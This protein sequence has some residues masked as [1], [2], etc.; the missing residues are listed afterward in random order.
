MAS[1]PRQ[2]LRILLLVALPWL[3]GN[4]APL[5]AEE[6]HTFFETKIRPI[7]VDHCST[8]H[9]EKLQ[10]ASLN[11]TTV[12]G[13]FKG[14]V[15]GPVVVK[16]DP[17]NSRIIQVV[18]YLDKI[19]MPPTGKLKEEEI[20]ALKAWV[21]MGTPWPDAKA[22]ATASPTSNEKY[23]RQP[24]R[25]WA[26][27]P[28]Q[29]Y[30]V[31]KVKDQSWIR[32]PIDSFILAKLEEQGLQPPLPADKLTL[33][34]RA[35]WDLH[36]LPPTRNEIEEFLS[37]D[38]PAAFS[39]LLDRLLASPR[40]GERWGRHWLDVARY[41]DSTGLDEDDPYY[42]GWR[43]RD[44]VID[45]FNKD[46]PFDQFIKEQ[47]AGDILAAEKGGVHESQ[48]VAT[49]FLA[50]GPKPIA[51]QDKVK[52]VY[53]VV[54]EQIDTTSKAFLGLTISCARCHDHKFDPI[55][56][57]DYYSLAA[58]FA[59]IRN[60]EDLKPVSA[61]T[62]VVPLVSK[63]VY[64]RYRDHQ[65]KV[66]AKEKE[67]S[68]VINAEKERRAAALR[69]HLAEYM[70][71]SWQ[72]ENRP[73]SMANLT[74]QQFASEMKLQPD[75]L[76]RWVRYLN[77]EQFRPHLKAW[78]QAIQE[79]KARQPAFTGSDPTT[80]ASK[81]PSVPE[82]L[83]VLAKTYQDEIERISREWESVLRD[84][85]QREESADKAGMPR[86]EKPVFNKVEHPFYTDVFLDDALFGL[87]EKDGEGLFLET[88][89]ARL[90]ALRDEEKALKSAGPPEPPLADAVAEGEIVEQAVF[91]RG[92]PHNPGAK[93]AKRFPAILA[94]DQQSPITQG[95]GRKELAAWLTQ[96]DHPL[97]S[98]VT[99]NRIWQWHFGEGLVRTP[100][101]FG[102][103]G[104][105]PT[106]PEL[107][108]YLAKQ[109]VRSG[110]S[111]KAMH[112]LIMLS[113]TYQMSGRISAKTWTEDPS[114]RL[115][116]RFN[117]RR[118]TVEEMRDGLLS[119]SGS[120]DLT[121]GGVISELA[122]SRSYAERNKSRVDP[123]KSCR[124]TVYLPLNRNKL[125]TL[126]SLFDF[127]D[128][129]T[130]TGKRTQTNVAP[131][132]LFIMNSQF[133]DKQAHALTR[134]LLDNNDA[135]VDRAKRAYLLLLTRE[136]TPEELEQGLRYIANYPVE[137]TT[138]LDAKTTAW[139]GFCRVLIASNEFHYLD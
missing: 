106:H 105:K 133:V 124:R 24:G 117:R 29:D 40:Y 59:C 70:L 28:I 61:K 46:L 38:S 39:R 131:Q 96:D 1:S 135:D 139:Q 4:S 81:V 129:T 56:T 12:E 103:T 115:W 6:G 85:K 41:A 130:S 99:V 2:T 10:M 18:S 121:M 60:Y 63:E 50:L 119:V 125:P 102:T 134:H 122:A 30:A 7:L 8:C 89:K 69:P 43:Y 33:L 66:E 32:T 9:G 55:S 94:G 92:S 113:S 104:E 25:H 74:V 42:H 126:L 78:H 51:Q 132:G 21:K 20:E 90:A 44:Y 19:K 127:V 109:F 118:L 67:I 34:R 136:P 76:D 58:I 15:S 49:G 120:L 77:P 37:D 16:G 87:P 48:I 62:Y 14:A 27:Q 112:R 31:P 45:S 108:D 72:Y 123:E 3:I 79:A 17:E 128:S 110:W 111:V 68:E 88:S 47:L 36:G 83:S 35:K 97:T 80:A 116:S 75:V 100:N 53:D 137:R 52:M 71:T 93:V 13:L 95:S 73:S 101:N 57:E 65:K 138:P 11:L 86:P 98:R 82:A 54:D 22:T 23:T 84:W 64:D 26:F 114:N 91:V 107:L 5:L